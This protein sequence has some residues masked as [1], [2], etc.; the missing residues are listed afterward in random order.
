MTPAE[1][2]GVLVPLLPLPGLPPLRATVSF[3]LNGNQPA[4]GISCAWDTE[5]HEGLYLCGVRLLSFVPYRMGTFIYFK[6]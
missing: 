5:G 6:P 2:Q 1:K 3:S 4:L